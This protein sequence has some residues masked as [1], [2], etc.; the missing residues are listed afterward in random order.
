MSTTPL[1]RSTFAIC[2]ASTLSSKSIVPMTCERIDGSCTNGDATG[3]LSAQP[4]STSL[5][6]RVRETAQSRPPWLFIHSTCSAMRKIV[7]SEGVL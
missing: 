6:S 5:L 2:A 1:A 3:L 4:Y 7:A